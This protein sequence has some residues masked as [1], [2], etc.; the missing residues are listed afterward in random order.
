VIDATC[1]ADRFRRARE[2]FNAAM[3]AGCSITELRQRRADERARLRERAP[4][5]V[6]DHTADLMDAP[7]LAQSDFRAWDSGWMMRD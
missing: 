7:A 3:E 4:V 1:Q 2:E 6:A 5:A